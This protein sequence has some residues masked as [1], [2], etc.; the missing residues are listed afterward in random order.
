MRTKIKEVYMKGKL[1]GQV[2]IFGFSL[3]LLLALSLASAGGG[4]AQ[5]GG[6]S[7][8]SAAGGASV[9][10]GGGSGDQSV[11]IGDRLQTRDRDQVSDQTRDQLK[12]RTRDST[13]DRLRTRGRERDRDLFFE[14]SEGKVHQWQTRFDHRLQKHEE[15]DDPAGLTRALHRIANRYRLSSD[16]A[17][18]FVTWALKHRPW[19][20]EG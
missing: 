5:G 6:T 11:G 19:A 20:I 10:T 7:G 12:D 14:D 8:S 4:S 17:E 3:I 18:G 9:Q 13:G 15:K 1:I 2:S 16:D